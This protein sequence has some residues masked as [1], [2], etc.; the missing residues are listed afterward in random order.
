MYASRCDYAK[1]TWL[2]EETLHKDQC[3]L[4][5]ESE[6]DWAGFFLYNKKTYISVILKN[7]WNLFVFR[8]QIKIV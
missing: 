7:R 2:Y 5:Q 3:E 6:R 8:M 1:G 4:F